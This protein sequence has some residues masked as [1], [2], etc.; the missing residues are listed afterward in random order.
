MIQNRILRFKGSGYPV[1]VVTGILLFFIFSIALLYKSVV[2]AAAPPT[3]ITY[4]GKLLE[5]GVAVSSTQAMGFL[6]YDNVAAGS[7]LYT[8][9]GSLPATSTLS[10]TPSSGIFSVN[11]GG[12][13]TNS[14]SPTIFADNTDLFL[15]IWIEGVKMTPR[16]RLTAAP[17]AINARYLLGISASTTATSTYIPISSA[18]GNFSFTG[19]PQSAAIGGGVVYI[20][21]AAADANETL[22]GVAL[23]GS[24]RLRLDEDGDLYVNGSANVTG[25]LRVSSTTT[26]D[27]RLIVS[28]TVL[29]G[30]VLHIRNN[31]T[32]IFVVDKNGNVGIN[33]SSPAVALA[34]SGKLIVTDTSTLQGVELAD[35]VV[36]G[37]TAGI[38]FSD[39]DDIANVAILTAEQTFTK[40][41]SFSATT[42]LATTTV[43][44]LLT[45]NGQT[46]GISFDDLD[47]TAGIA[48]LA[49]IQTFTGTNTF[50]ATT[51][52]VTTTVNGQLSV[53]SG[54]LFVDSTNNRVGVNSTSPQYA[55][56]VSGTLGVTGTSS[57]A[58]TSIS[59]RLTVTGD[60]VGISFSDLSDVAN[61]ALLN[62]NQTFTGTNTFSAT[63][64]LAT[65]TVNGRLNVDSG[66]LFVD[67]ANNRVG[68]N[69]SSPQHSFVV[70]GESY[71]TATSTFLNGLASLYNSD[72]GP[73]NFAAL[74]IGTSTIA[75]RGGLISLVGNSTNKAMISL[76]DGD[77]A[78]AALEL[79]ATQG[80]LLLGSD[81]VYG[82][83]IL[84]DSNNNT[85]FY[86]SATSTDDSYIVGDFLIGES[87]EAITT[88]TF[89]LSGDDAYVHDLLGVGDS[90][91]VEN[92]IHVGTSSLHLTGA[93]SGG[94]ISMTNGPLTIDSASNQLNINTLNNRTVIFG[95]GLAG[96]NS[97]SPQ[98][99]L[100]VGGTFGVSS[101]STLAGVNVNG[102][103]TVNGTVSGISSSDLDDAGDVAM[104]SAD[105][106][107]T[108]AKTFTATT[109]LATTSLTGQLSVGTGFNVNATNGRVGI[110]ST[111]P[112]FALGVGGTVGLSGT[113]T[114]SDVLNVSG[115][116]SKPVVVGS[117]TSSTVLGSASEIVVVG[118]Y[119]YVGSGTGT[120]SIFDISTPTN[121]TFV[122]VFTNTALISGR[123]SIAIAG[124]YAYV[125]N[126]GGGEVVVDVSDPANPSY[127]GE[128]PG[129]A[130]AIRFPVVVGNMVVG[131]DIVGNSNP[132]ILDVTNP[133]LPQRIN[134]VGFGSTDSPS[135]IAVSGRYAF[136][137]NNSN[138]TL[139]VFDISNPLADTEVGTV[140]STLLTK[141]SA[142]EIRG[143]HAFIAAGRDAFAASPTNGALV[144]VDISNPSTPAVVGSITSSTAS[145][146]DA[147]KIAVSGDYAFVT[148]YGSDA[149]SIINVSDPTS[150][151]EVAVITS[152][153]EPLL[154][155]PTG[156]AVSGNYVYVVSEDTASLIVVDI[157]GAKIAHADIGAAR[158]SQLQVLGSTNFNNSVHIRGGLNIGEGGLLL[159]GEFGIIAPT[160]SVSAT[161]TLR[162]SHGVQ[163]LSN[164]TSS[165]SH[166]FVFDTQNT[167]TTGTSTYLLSIRN[168]GT[169][170]FSVATNGDVHA[171]GDLFAASATVGTSTN[172]GDLAERVDVA[173]EEFIEPGDVLVVD[174]DE[175]DRYRRSSSAYAAEVAG[176]VSTNPT[177]TIGRGRTESTSVMA[178]VGRVPVK[179]S[180]ENGPIERGDLLVTAT[181]AGYAMRY[182]PARDDGLRT[183]SI[184][185]VAL[186]PL[187]E[188]TGKKMALVR[189]GWINN[190]HQS[191]AEIQHNLIDIAE[192]S[193]VALA[194]NPVELNVVE[195][196]NGQIGEVRENLNL[197]GYYIVNVAAL[198]GKDDRWQIDEDGRFITKVATSDGS[199]SLY[200][201]QS[202]ETE[203]IFSGSGELNN[204]TA[205]I[206]FDTV[207]RDIID[208]E[209]PVKVTIT[210]TEQ[211]KGV[212]VTEKDVLG[213]RVN[214]LEN[215]NSNATFDWLVIAR[216]KLGEE[217]VQE[218]EP[219]VEEQQEEDQERAN[220]EVE[221]PVAEEQVVEQPP[222]QKVQEEPAPKEP[223]PAE[224]PPEANQGV[225]VEEHA[226]Q[227]PAQEAPPVDLP[228]EAAPPPQENPNV[229]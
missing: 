206:D 142:V 128:T 3:I 74:Q 191:I 204:G 37:D 208:P 34:V 98:F 168:A 167:L 90:L 163:F 184:I 175:T 49:G 137:T 65:T 32:P 217:A 82:R 224:D 83:I 156:V 145:V 80:N 76:N 56:G 44:G 6:I 8:A 106:S 182:D 77:E 94:L 155:G 132:V 169:R 140:V 69:S 227:Q 110:S 97:S 176:V 84:S 43:N 52:L 88:S 127:A 183:V 35:L 104:L 215:G 11:L 45:L 213:F 63:T 15:E 2:L 107:F 19:T 10:I 174:P 62:A 148:G 89:V 5:D 96:F 165:A 196:A 223:V 178:M 36:T 136:I 28:S 194:Q 195:Q 120:L 219:V 123:V 138:D 27:S 58:T 200:A 143:N 9:S 1:L 220:E 12:T 141:S 100:S 225:V 51:T 109:T 144:V 147:S 159:R 39:L 38:S 134:A 71:F 212:Y 180:A 78:G 105:Q 166:A 79:T 181:L 162:F 67:P 214:E 113:T 64:T 114:V 87:A 31:G 116:V 14:L 23:N 160:S 59:G 26:L 73:L 192:A 112:Q 197:N 117:F 207:T 108:G 146:L 101:T 221:V 210:L 228:A 85:F 202:R 86:L 99:Q 130:L 115:R 205:R 151:D 164:V 187:E 218:D 149:L 190:R 150:L 42:T 57:L 50:S 33:T 55:L 92:A 229:E 16:K 216:R 222:A 199:T 152:S 40:Q 29:T 118:D 61:V 203:Y 103:L 22:F 133:T 47:D 81:N 121:P 24:E 66:T 226:E 158:V 60:T 95:S 188:G 131:T 126:G 30:D 13:G 18:N 201:L 189:T 153:T 122:G 193:G 46:S 211:A 135:D 157:T 72:I 68:V 48:L 93:T 172:P 91:F 20:N 7:L 177:I 154:D 179:M 209:Q 125:S 185:G 198:F 53:D 171:A 41:N 139:T 21:P 4:Q 70:N 186:E 119:A 170:L 54:T 17:Y 75:G 124:K 102:A 111:S 173:P 25:T 161:N 129:F